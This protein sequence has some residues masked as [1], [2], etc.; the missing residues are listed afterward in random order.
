MTTSPRA[1]RSTRP[2]AA[3]ADF[4]LARRTREQ[5][6]AICGRWLKDNPKP[7]TGS[8]S[9][10]SIRQD[11]EYRYSVLTAIAE[12]KIGLE[13]PDADDE[14]NAVYAA[15]PA[16]WQ[17]DSTRQRIQELQ[18]LIAASPLKRLRVA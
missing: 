1:V 3:V 5:V 4:I 7:V 9:E 16:Q 10:Q 17:A 8:A 14:L 12:A 18:A 11:A 15:A 13:R 2:A 6:L